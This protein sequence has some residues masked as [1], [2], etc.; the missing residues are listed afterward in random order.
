MNN[1]RTRKT[2]L[3]ALDLADNERARYNVI[4][5]SIIIV[6]TMIETSA[7]KLTKLLWS[8]LGLIGVF[9]L[10][11]IRLFIVIVSMNFY[12]W[13]FGQSEHHVIGYSLFLSWLAVFLLLF[14]KRQDMLGRIQLIYSQRSPSKLL[15]K[16]N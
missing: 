2:V 6:V 14:T 4:L 9:V 1:T 15:S 8:G 5:F 7:S 13:D 3:T 16:N 12:G 11:V 10:N